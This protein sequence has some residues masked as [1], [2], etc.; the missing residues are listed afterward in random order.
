MKL[1]TENG[2]EFEVDDEWVPLV[3]RFRWWGFKKPNGQHYIR[4][5]VGRKNISLHRL[6]AGLA[7]SPDVDHKNREPTD[8]RQDNLRIA[9]AMNHAN[10]KYSRSV[11]G[12][13]GVYKHRNHWCM[14]AECQGARHKKVGFKTPEEAARAYDAVAVKLWGEFAILNFP[15]EHGL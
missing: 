4:S 15:S 2:I 1:N 3:Q 6:I 7:H 11:S 9:G 8:N 12:F 5:N 10:R 13:R 14:Q